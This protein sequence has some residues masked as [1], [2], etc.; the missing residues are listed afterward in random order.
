MED[1]PGAAAA[2][3]HLHLVGDPRAGRVDQVDH[4]QLERAAPAPGSGGSSRPSSG[5]TSPALTV[6]SLAISA[7]LAAAD[8]R[9]AGDDAVGAEALLRPSWRAAPPRRT[10]PGR[11]AARPARGPRS[12]P[13][14]AVFS[15]WRSG[16]PASAASS[17]RSKLGAARASR[18][19]TRS[20][21]RGRRRARSS[22]SGSSAT[23]G[24]GSS[25]VVARRRSSAARLA[26]ASAPAVLGRGRR[27]C[28]LASR[29][30]SSST[31]SRRCSRSAITYSMSRLAPVR[32]VD[33]PLRLALGA[34]R[35]P[36]VGL[37]PLGARLVAPS[38]SRARG[39]GVGL[40]AGLARVGVGLV[41]RRRRRTRRPRRAVASARRVRVDELLA[42]L[43]LG[44]VADRLAPP[45]AASVR[46]AAGLLADPLELAPGRPPSAALVA[47]AGL[48]PVGELGRGSWSTSRAVVAAHGEREGRVADALDRVLVHACLL[49]RRWSASSVPRC[50]SPRV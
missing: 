48:E 6:G 34:R 50:G 2:G 39:V 3:E 29:S 17:A 15:W 12:L 4:R 47:A 45:R 16:P 42:H 37:A 49:A 43:A 25:A 1:P 21:R 5:P 44:L 23:V 28:S 26:S 41:A 33:D 9:Q 7:D 10:T 22:R 8:Q 13:C 36:R 30:S 31:A 11:R 32:L 46:I 27:R 19:A 14:S 18:S 20:A 35:A 38:A 40:A 24:L